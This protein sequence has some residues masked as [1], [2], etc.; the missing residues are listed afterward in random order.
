MRLLR[1]HIENF[2]VLSGFDYEFPEGLAVICRE[3]GF[4]KSTLAAFLKAMFYG[5]PRTGAHNV[6]ENERRRFEPWQGGKFGGFLEFEYQ[7]AAYR[8]TRYFGKT[9]AKDTFS[10]RDLTRRTDETPWTRRLL[11]AAP[12]CRRRQRRI[13][14]RRRR[15]AQSF[16]IWSTT[17]TT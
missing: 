1:C 3:N 15:C 16:P 17:R 4:G 9:A 6:T 8:V 7:G 11:R 10:L 5:L 14:R 2:G 12:I 13:C